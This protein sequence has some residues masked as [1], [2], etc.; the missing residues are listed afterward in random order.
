[1]TSRAPDLRDHVSVKTET[2]MTLQMF[3]ATALSCAVVFI[4]AIDPSGSVNA[5]VYE[6]IGRVY[7]RR[8]PFEDALGGRHVEDI[9]VYYSSE[10]LVRLD[11]NGRELADLPF[12]AG[13]PHLA[14]AIG[15]MQAL[16]ELHV[17]AGAVTAAQLDSLRDF[18]VIVLPDVTRLSELEAQAFKKYVEAGGRLY[19]SGRTG[20]LSTAGA[21]DPPLLADLLG[22]DVVGDDD[23]P[24]V[25]LAP[26]C[27]R[28]EQAIFPQR[29]VSWPRREG[30]TVP[31]RLQGR[32][33]TEMLAAL[34]LPYAYPEPGTRVDQ[35]WSSN[36]SFPPWSTTAH[37]VI[38]EHSTGRGRAVYS[39]FPLETGGAAAK[40][41][42]KAMLADLI[43]D[44]VHVTAEAAD[45]V[46][47]ET[48]AQQEHSR[49]VV[50][51]LNY[52]PDAIGL[53]TPVTIGSGCPPEPRS[54]E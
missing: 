51:V 48:F 47:I 13:S 1:M 37:P 3:G 9:G 44:G 10:S 4:D 50:S 26:A 5:A 7:E 45:S 22:V 15:A 20:I 33:G 12:A 35:N 30:T 43:G 25:S 14:A 23:G 16:Q 40:S 18:A 21:V 41:L 38:T 31:P 54:H 49:Y 42:L 29:H 46:W 52:A 39:A 11:D 2:Q 17:P 28:V 8:K 24:E 27:S 6:Q 53:P 34:C 36:Y 19:A 32:P